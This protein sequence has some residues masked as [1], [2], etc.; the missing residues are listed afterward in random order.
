MLRKKIRSF[1][2]DDLVLIDGTDLHHIRILRDTGV[3]Q[4]FLSEGVLPLRE[5]L[6]TG[7]DVLIQGVWI[8]ERSFSW[9]IFTI[10][11]CVWKCWGSWG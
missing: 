11:L 6:F 10:R 9:D 7:S 4:S 8:C 1:L 3:S 2:F 5:N